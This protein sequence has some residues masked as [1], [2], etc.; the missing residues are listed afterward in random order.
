LLLPNGTGNVGIGTASPTN[1]LHLGLNSNQSI[2]VNSG[3]SNATYL[4]IFN[5]AGGISVNRDISNGVFQDSGKATA[6][7]YVRGEVSNGYITFET[8]G[9]NNVNSTERMRITST[10]NV[11]IG[12]ASP[13]AFGTQRFLVLGSGAASQVSRFTDGANADLVFDFPTQGVSR[14]TSQFGTSG[15]FVFSNG[16][17]FTERMRLDSSGNLGLGVTPSAWRSVDRALQIGLG[18]FWS[19]TQLT[20]NFSQNHYFSSTGRRY[21]A[22]GRATDYEQY[23]GYHAWKTAANNTSGAGAA[24]TF[25]QAM[26]L[27]S[28]SGLSIGTPSAAPAQGL[29]VQGAATF[30]SSVTAGNYTANDSTFA[31]SPID[32]LR[33]KAIFSAANISGSALTL[34][35]DSA[36]RTLR[37]S[38]NTSPNVIGALDASATGISLG[39]NNDS[40]VIFNIAGTERMRIWSGTGT[41]NVNIGTTPASNSGFRLDVNGTARVTGDFTA[42]SNVG[43]KTAVSSSNTLR[44]AGNIVGALTSNGLE[45]AGVVQSTVT[46]AAR[47]F[48]GFGSVQNTAFTLPNLFI[49][50]AD[51]SPSFGSAT[52]TNQYGYYV[53]S[54]FTGATNNYGFFGN[55]NSGANRW[56]LYMSGSAANYLAGNLGIGITAPT[57]RLDIGNGTLTLPTLRGRTYTLSNVSSANPNFING[58]GFNAIPV[59]VGDIIDLPFS[60]TRTVTAVTDTQLTVD[61]AWTTSFAGVNVEGRGAIV[62]QTNNLDRLTIAGTGNVLIGTTSDNGARLQ[63]SGDARVSGVV[64]SDAA[65]GLALGSVAGYRRLQ[66]DLANTRFSVLTDS[67]TSANFEA[68]NGLFISGTNQNTIGSGS[69]SLINFSA[70]NSSANQ[71]ITLGLALDTAVNNNAAY[72]YLFNV[73]GNADGQNLTLSSRRR[74]IA[75]LTILTVNGNN[76]ASTFGSSVTGSAFIPSGSTIPTNGMYLPSANTIAFSTNTTE[77]MRITSGGNVLIGIATDNANKLRVNGNV[78]IDG[79]VAVNAIIS[80]DGAVNTFINPIGGSIIYGGNTGGVH[81]FLINSSERFRVTNTEIRVT[82]NVLINNSVSRFVGFGTG[83]ENPYVQFAQNGSM[84]FNVETNDTYTFQRGGSSFVTFTG[85]GIETLAGGIRTVAPTGTA[86]ENWRLGRALLATSSDPEDT[87]IRVQLG[88]KIYDILAIDRGN[89]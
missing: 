28:N 62:F 65:T 29:L 51:S 32:T 42:S 72:N 83:T 39:S 33:T 80:T 74:G 81:Q 16:T 21:I 84:L 54:T 3:N 25:T 53:E 69:L 4:G 55:I 66:Y 46:T 43:I 23:D 14:I 59:R 13:S 12:T 45:N 1:R 11:G 18:S 9:T 47:Y 77:A 86:H 30:S 56:N 34:V 68:L 61:S 89:A 52:V 38:S 88:T 64:R 2:K 75:D 41:G 19:D 24:L 36:G 26:T 50:R 87:W 6:A 78:W 49:Y 7:I 60:Q 35:S 40:P 82:G 71:S 20:A 57:T 27:G 85:N 31:V 63:V 79:N 67:N 48:N 76:G 8:T 58:T 17:G 22:N 15:A 70:Y 5:D 10:G 73:G 37:L 44:I